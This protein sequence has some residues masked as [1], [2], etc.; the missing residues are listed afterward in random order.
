MFELSILID[1]D[2][3]HLR[4]TITDANHAIKPEGNYSN[5]LT[6][7]KSK[8]FKALSLHSKGIGTKKIAA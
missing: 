2:S 4:A 7:K 8:F 1:L 5:A 6:Y 3:Q